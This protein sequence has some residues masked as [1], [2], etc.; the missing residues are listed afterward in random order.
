MRLHVLAPL[1][2]VALAF[3]ATA[4]GA[5]PAVASM[6]QIST[7]IKIAGLDLQTPADAEIALRRIGQAARAICGDESGVR[8]L[9]RQMLSDACV[10]RAVNTAVASAHSPTLAALNGT[11]AVETAVAAAD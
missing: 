10:R 11:P 3:G 2:A 6:D 1:V 9:R 8:D 7:R 4:A 5:A